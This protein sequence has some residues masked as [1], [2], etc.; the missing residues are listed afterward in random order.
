MT[1]EQIFGLASAAVLPGWAILIA[2]PRRWTWATAVPGLVLPAGLSA[3]Y[4]V[5][6]L[7]HFWQA[8]GG[9]GSLAD[10][11]RLFANDWALLAGWV[12]Y[13]AFDL[14]LGTIVAGRMDR[15]GVSRL[16]QAPILV[17]TFLLGP[18][19]VVLALALAG[20]L[21]PAEALLP[22]GMKARET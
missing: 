12:H 15:A 11:R 2:A 5:L 21:R 17:L 13:L 10:V 14:A 9:F 18:L 19:G 8:D 20:A 4:A 6:V 3:L 16:I 22:L 1:P 7:T